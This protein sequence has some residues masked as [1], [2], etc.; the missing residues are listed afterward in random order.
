MEDDNQVMYK[1][2]SL[3]ALLKALNDKLDKYIEESKRDHSDH[4]V[5][6][7]NL[8][9]GQVKIYT[10]AGTI[11]AVGSLIITVVGKWLNLS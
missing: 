7:R 11:G 6:I 2:G 4:D 1:L 5:R 10:I 9:T 3:E 8:E